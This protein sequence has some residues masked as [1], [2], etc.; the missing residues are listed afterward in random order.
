MFS[1][2]LFVFAGRN[3]HLHR[4]TQIHT[5]YLANS[6]SFLNISRDA[7][8]AEIFKKLIGRMIFVLRFILT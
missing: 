6:E 4:N 1:I 7:T 3:I 5:K 2:Y 8:Y